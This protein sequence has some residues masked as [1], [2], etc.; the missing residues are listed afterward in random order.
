M[1][2][3][4]YY[5]PTKVVFGSGAELKAGEMLREFGATKVLIH[6]G[7]QSAEKTGLLDRVRSSIREAGISFV[8][9]GGVVPNPRLS[10]VREGIALAKEENVDFLLAVG[11]GSVID[12]T[13][14]IA[15]GLGEP[16]Y[17]VWELFSRK[18][19]AKKSFPL[20]TVLTI[21]AAG[22]E[23]SSSCVITNEETGEKRGYGNNLSR[24]K[25][26]LLNPELTLTLPEYQTMSGCADIMMHTMERYFTNTGNMTIT[27]GLAEGLMKAVMQGARD[28]LADPQDLEARATV[29]WA[30]A[31]SHNG[32]TGCG[33]EPGDWAT[34]RLEHELS[35][36]FDVTHGAG[37]TALWG[38]WARYV[39]QNCLHRFVKFAVDVMQVPEQGSEEATALAGIEAAE[40]FFREIGMPTCIRDLGIQLSASGLDDL[41]RR[42]VIAV[43]GRVGNARVLEEPDIRAIYEMA[44]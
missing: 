17:D 30:G 12:S 15:Y 40:D 37:L 22:S 11:G 38:S 39:Y 1:N 5:T 6:Y 29:M 3:F 33:A 32:L 35:G 10:K 13:K 31:L 25:F 14:A 2:N 44:Q 21:A 27:D 34:H 36:K 23:M 42:C 19:Q 7:G 16:E 9:L 24:A 20:G 41:T 18:R 43:N 26:S 8:E 4:I 28:L